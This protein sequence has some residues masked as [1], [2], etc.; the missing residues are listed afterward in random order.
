MT[1]VCALR[2]YLDEEGVFVDALNSDDAGQLNNGVLL[3]Q[4]L[5]TGH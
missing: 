2:T 4:F 1:N 5:N 3:F